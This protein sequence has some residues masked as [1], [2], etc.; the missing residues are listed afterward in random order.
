MGPCGRDDAILGSMLGFPPLGW[1]ERIP[2]NMG[3]NEYDKKTKP[4]SI[5]APPLELR[6]W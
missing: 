5:A 2:I 1:K 4:P 6:H 3:R